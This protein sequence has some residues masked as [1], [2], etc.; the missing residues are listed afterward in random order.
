[1]FELNEAEIEALT[2]IKQGATHHDQVAKEIKVSRSHANHIIMSLCEKG[3][4]EK[5]RRGLT[6]E[7]RFTN[8][9]FVE[10]FKRLIDAHLPLS[11][12]LGG[13]KVMVLALFTG[14][15]NR[16]SVSDLVLL[17]GLSKVTIWRYLTAWMDHGIMKK[18]PYGYRI[19]RSSALLKQFL[20]EYSR[21]HC[22]KAV[23]DVSPGAVM[24]W[25]LGFE[26]V[27]SLPIGIET[28]VGRTTGIA[29]FAENGV[30]F[31]GSREYRHIVAF[32]RRFDLADAILD[33][34]VIDPLNWTSMLNSLICLGARTSLVE[35]D[36]LKHL[37]KAYG[38]GG[39]G[40]EM[41][42]YIK[43]GN[44][45]RETFPQYK[46]YKQK[47]ALYLEDGK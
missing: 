10:N 8:N 28:A 17:T 24:L 38:L 7:I 5:T 31:F 36:R 40:S 21:F 1:M 39:L 6:Y 22:I 26:C 44:R 14:T 16:L 41:F 11:K 37:A 3:F 30:A 12:L 25:N 13:N 9:L 20:V 19:S 47:L 34:I 42:D 4:L 27:Y 32:D 46:E 2:A 29:A 18:I 45:A 33:N 35:E 15:L 23:S 43:T